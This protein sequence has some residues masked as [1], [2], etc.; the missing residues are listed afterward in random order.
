MIVMTPMSSPPT[1]TYNVCPFPV[2]SVFFVRICVCVGEGGGS[3]Q[4]SLIFLTYW[5]V[6]VFARAR[7]WVWVHALGCYSP[8]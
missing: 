5:N 8:S 1:P 6:G 7:A 3:G 4:L 2:V